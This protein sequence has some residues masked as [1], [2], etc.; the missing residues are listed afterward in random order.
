MFNVG[1]VVYLKS[2]PEV[3]MTVSLVLEDMDSKGFINKYLK[4]QLQKIGYTNGAIECSWFC[5]SEHLREF[6]KPEMLVKKS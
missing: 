1:D 5:E 6:F 4:K 3:L 2:N